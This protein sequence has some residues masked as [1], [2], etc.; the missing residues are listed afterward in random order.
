MDGRRAT[1]IGLLRAGS[2][3]KGASGVRNKLAKI[4][5]GFWSHE[6]REF[7]RLLGVQ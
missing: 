3:R 2:W 6:I 7:G 5:D 1:A 4:I